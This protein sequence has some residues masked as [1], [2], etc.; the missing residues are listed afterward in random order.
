MRKYHINKSLEHKCVS[1][2]AHVLITEPTEVIHT[3]QEAT[4]YM[5]NSIYLINSIR[6]TEQIMSLH[7]APAHVY[8]CIITCSVY[9]TAHMSVTWKLPGQKHK[10][11]KRCDAV[12]KLKAANFSEEAASTVRL[13]LEGDKH[14]NVCY[15]NGEKRELCRCCLGSKT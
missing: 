7:A 8:I 15:S 2:R 13:P 9:Q 14:L 3:E 11:R 10:D 6:L 12:I 5:E 4:M 1:N